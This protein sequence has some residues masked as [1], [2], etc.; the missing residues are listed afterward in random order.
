[1]TTLLLI[2]LGVLWLASMAVFAVA[3]LSAPTR[4]GDRSALDRADRP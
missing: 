3:V 2:V 1:M 4:P